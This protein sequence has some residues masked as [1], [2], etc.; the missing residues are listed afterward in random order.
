MAGRAWGPGL[1]G[2]ARRGH[3]HPY[4]PWPVPWSAGRPRA[5]AGTGDQR[6]DVRPVLGWTDAADVRNPLTWLRHRHI[7]GGRRGSRT[8]AALPQTRDPGRGC[9]GFDAPLGA[10][11]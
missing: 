5:R 1:H 9:H 8:W 4:G 2:R 6:A 7:Y 10:R 11:P 3:S